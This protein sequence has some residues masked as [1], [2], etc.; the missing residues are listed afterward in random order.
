MCYR[1]FPV[2]IAAFSRCLSRRSL[3]DGALVHDPASR[4]VSNDLSGILK[5]ELLKQ[6]SSVR[7]DSSRTDREHVSDFFA[8]LSFRD[9]LQHLA[10]A[11]GERIVAIGDPSLGQASDVVIEHDLRDGGTEERFAGCNGTNGQ[12]EIAAI[13]SEPADS[14]NRYPRA[15]AWTACVT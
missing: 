10:L 14:F 12:D 7:F 3:G 1:V 15:P 11:F 6:M 9:Q 13:N 8:A 5:A 2:F 4:R